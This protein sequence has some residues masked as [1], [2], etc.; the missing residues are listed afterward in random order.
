[1]E[2]TCRQYEIFLLIIFYLLFFI[3]G[4]Q[5][6]T[7]LHSWCLQ[8]QSCVIP[9]SLWA[10]RVVVILIMINIKFFTQIFFCLSAELNL[11]FQRLQ[12]TLH[13]FT[14]SLKLEKFLLFLKRK[15]TFACRPSISWHR[16]TDDRRSF[17]KWWRICKL[18]TR[19]AHRP[20]PSRQ[21][22]ICRQTLRCVII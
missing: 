2:N 9:L 3:T 16:K 15:I 8:S 7:H 13:H 21:T 17:Q 19:M 5:C 1:M 11:A 14:G 10:L 4:F 6:V 18:L 12:Q 20:L 22:W